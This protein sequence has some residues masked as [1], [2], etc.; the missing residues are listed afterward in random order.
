MPIHDHATYG[1]QIAGA[2]RAEEE[3]RMTDMCPTRVIP[4]SERHRNVM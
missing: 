2:T 3:T 1:E 4:P